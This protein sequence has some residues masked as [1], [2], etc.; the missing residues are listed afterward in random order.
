MKSFNY[1]I[2]TDIKDKK[3]TSDIF[4]K[5]ELTL[6][7]KGLKSPKIFKFNLASKFQESLQNLY[8]YGVKSFLE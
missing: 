6:G 7:C 4:F 2:I 3:K 5:A 8:F 1:G